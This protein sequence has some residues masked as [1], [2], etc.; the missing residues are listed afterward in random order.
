MTT[1]NKIADFLLKQKTFFLAPHERADGDALGSLLALSRA[2]SIHGKTAIPLLL[3]EVSERYKFLFPNGTL[4]IVTKT[5]PIPPADAIILIDTAVRQQVEPLLPILDRHD[6]KLIIIDHHAKCDLNPDLKLIDEKSPAAALIVA[7][8]LTK[9]KWLDN[10]QI[11]E[12]LLVGIASDTGWFSYNNTNADCFSWAAKLCRLGASSSNIYEK[13]FLSD[14]P[15]RFRLFSKALANTEILANGKLVVM[16]LRQKD[17]QTC[18]AD[19]AHT[20]N[21]IDQASRL[22]SMLAAIL[23]VEQSDGII[24]ISM[25]SRDPFD[26][27]QFA[28]QFGGGGHKRAAGMRIK[29][30]IDHVKKKVLS[31]LEKQ[32]ANE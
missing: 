12:Y 4:P 2:L 27:N 18:G 7:K 6:T 17:F 8:L 5:D 19:Q 31:T 32:L 26:V 28:T 25:R 11:A 20:E 10:P 16:T 15:Q 9:L 13:L 14:S 1:L 23:F 22:K 29:G 3:G 21:L 24:R 30:N